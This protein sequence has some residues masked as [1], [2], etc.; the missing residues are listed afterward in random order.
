MKSCD[1][2]TVRPRQAIQQ[3]QAERPPSEDRPGMVRLHLNENTA[4]A[5]PAVVRR[6]RQALEGKWLASYPHYEQARAILATHFGVAGEEL[7]LT[8]GI[9]DA[10]KLICDTFVEPGDR[11]L[12]PALTFP[13]YRFFHALAGGKTAVVHHDA[14]LR[15]PLS[16]VL[17]AL[18]QRRTRWLA[19]A[20]PN[21][22]TATLVSRNDL[23]VLLRAAPRTLVLVDEAYFDF[24]GKTVLPW[25][26]SFPNLVVARTFSKAYGLAGLR[27]GLLF[28]PR[29]LAQ[30]MRRAQPVFPVNSVALTA[31]L[32]AVRHPDHLRRHAQHVRQN[33]ARL[34]RCLDSFGIPY[35]PSAAN[36]VF[37]CFGPNAG[38]I[39]RKLAERGIL[40]RHWTGDL[41]LHPYF[42]I[43]IG[44]SSET[45]RLIRAFESLRQR[46]EPQN[47]EFAWRG[48]TEYSPPD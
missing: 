7:L 30:G 40:V 2:V 10:I 24:S 3:L 8:N 22:P 32:E 6:L 11:L 18:R 1:P 47:P 42:R 27:L 39:A 20:N 38:E 44:T 4:G 9:D 16:H 21:N 17:A 35:A 33:R 46:I 43:G 14:K 12:I 45:G 29:Q 23:G 26:R 37:A 41:H 36:F 25:I 31:A 15:L 19:L 28:A 13:M 48:V 34:C 5:A